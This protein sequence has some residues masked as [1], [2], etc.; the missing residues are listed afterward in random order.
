MSCHQSSQ[1]TVILASPMWVE[2]FALILELFC[3]LALPACY[4]WLLYDRDERVEWVRI[5]IVFAVYRAVVA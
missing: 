2:I 1:L 3:L 5:I 4:V